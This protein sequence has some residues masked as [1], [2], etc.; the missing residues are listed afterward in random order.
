MNLGGRERLRLQTGVNSALHGSEVG[1]G[2]SCFRLG[3]V[4][5]RFS[6]FK[7]LFYKNYSYL[8]SIFCWKGDTE[9]FFNDFKSFS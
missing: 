6:L 5:F 8:C 2:L 9:H 4:L 7:N 3:L 1:R